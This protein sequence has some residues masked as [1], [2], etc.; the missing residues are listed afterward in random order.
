MS[1]LT[2]PLN[3]YRY[4]ALDRLVELE[5]LE[6]EKLTRF[7]RGEHLVTQLK[8]QDGYCVLQH[9]RQ[10]L[11]VQ[12][13]DGAERNSQ[14]LVT[15]QQRSALQMAGPDGVVLQVYAPYGHRRVESGTGGLLG[16]TGEVVDPATGHYLLGNGHRAFNPVL[17]RFNSP[18]SLSPFGRGGLNPY[19]YC[20]GD[21][22]NFSDPTGR[23]VNVLK[24][25]TSTGGLFSSL[26]TLKPSVSFKVANKALANG[27]VF[28]ASPK[29]IVGAMASATGGIM[30]VGVAATG[31]A[32]TIIAAVDPESPLITPLA[33]VSAALVTGAVLGKAGS[34]WV[35]LDP[36]AIAGLKALGEKQSGVKGIAVSR[37]SRPSNILL[38]RNYEPS[39]PDPS[40][41]TP[42]ANAPPLDLF[43]ERPFNWMTP[44]I[45]AALRNLGG[46][47]SLFKFGSSRRS[48][49]S[50]IRST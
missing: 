32:S 36:K 17:M 25:F 35:A 39:A 42:A 26:L 3:R 40:Q 34:A 9:D 33:F 11:A 29:Q 20:L 27:A 10:L 31:L 43:D 7:Y 48:S 19:A 45:D 22:V 46:E 47:A 16:F 41:F 6:L 18:D 38:P 21:P 1:A 24:I 28:R 50:S 12:S 13:F 44:E 14:L 4:D 2:R 23:F 37:S 15:D 30:G 49:I 5:P 8:G